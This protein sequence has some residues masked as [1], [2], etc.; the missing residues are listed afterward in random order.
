MQ[1]CVCG[2][3]GVK[4]I[5]RVDQNYIYTVYILYFWQGYIIF[6]IYGHVR[7][8]Y[9]QCSL[10]VLDAPKGALQIVPPSFLPLVMQ[11]TP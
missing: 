4:C 3:A 8:M 9:L 10:W 7:Y 1:A 2:H 11:K 5:C 6:Q